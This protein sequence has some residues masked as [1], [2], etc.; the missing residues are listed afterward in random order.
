MGRIGVTKWVLVAVA[1]VALSSVIILYISPYRVGRVIGEYKGAQVH[2]NGNIF[3]RS[4]GKNFAE[5]GYY[6]GQKWQCTE[7][8]KRFYHVAKAHKMPDVWGHAKDYFDPAVPHGEMNVRRNMLQFRNGGNEAP[9]PDD[10]LVFTGT[11]YG[12]VAIV[13]D[14]KEDKVVIVQQNIFGR[15]KDIYRLKVTDGNYFIDHP[16]IPAGWLRVITGA[17]NGHE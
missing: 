16:R 17:D 10:L 15:P 2:E 4:H 8:V 13:S 3:Y 11:K 5:D 6:Y 7:F 14:I 9:R 12:H 1:T